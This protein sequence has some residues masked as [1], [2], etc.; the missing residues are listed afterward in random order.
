MAIEPTTPPGIDA[1]PSTVPNRNS[2]TPAQF[3]NNTDAYLAAQLPFKDQLNAMSAWT[4]STAQEVY[5]NATA[6]AALSEYKGAWADLTGALN[7]PA[8]VSDNGGIYIL[9]AD[10]ADVTLWQP[11]LNLDK[12]ILSVDNASLRARAGSA[13]APSFT[14]LASR[15][16]NDG[17]L[18]DADLAYMNANNVSIRTEINNTVSGIGGGTYLVKTTAEKDAGVWAGSELYSCVEVASSGYWACLDLSKNLVNIDSLGV[19]DYASYKLAFGLNTDLVLND[20]SL[21]LASPSPNTTNSDFKMTDGRITVAPDASYLSGSAGDIN[22][23]GLLE[24]DDYNT[25][26]RD[27]KFDGNGQSTTTAYNPAAVNAWMIPFATKSGG[28]RVKFRDLDITDNGGHALETAQTDMATAIGITADNH[29]GIGSTQGSGHVY[30]LISSRDAHDSHFFLN[31]IDNTVLCGWVADTTTNGGGSD[32]AGG[33]DVLISSGVSVNSKTAATW[34][35]KSPNTGA[36]ANRVLV[37]GLISHNNS[38]DPVTAGSFLIGDY[39][40]PTEAQGEDYFVT[41]SLI[42]VT[43]TVLSGGSEFNSAVQTTQ[44]CDSL[45]FSNHHICGVITPSDASMYI[46]YGSTDSAYVNN[47]AQFGS[48]YAKIFYVNKPQGRGS[49]WAGNVG[50]KVN[51]EST[52]KPTIMHDDDGYWR[53][54]IQHKPATTALFDFVDIAYQG[55]FTRY[56]VELTVMQS[57]SGGML[58][59]RISLTGYTGG[60]TVVNENIDIV[61][62]GTVAT[63]GVNITDNTKTRIEVTPANTD[64]LFLGLRVY[65]VTADMSSISMWPTL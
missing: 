16:T 51:P 5:N 34:I 44:G 31:S 1:L 17:V 64:T 42:S 21:V 57:G 9:I 10:V 48:D 36:L 60:A 19:T 45:T 25:T 4:E 39:N 15:I 49:V 8:S 63:V 28:D 55:G 18:S 62:F 35:L 13:V 65:G 23:F 14:S 6:T 43:D 53:Y 54:T 29:N 61:N 59:K 30:G 26:I 52:Y 58:Q 12:W 3:S 47:I 33:N 41:S 24:I 20:I 56:I 50:S 27:V 7:I 2:D 32:V 22:Y 46:D 38:Q 40:N 11:S 37:N